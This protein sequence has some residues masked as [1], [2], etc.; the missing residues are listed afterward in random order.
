MNYK[1]KNF[2]SVIYSRE[3]VKKQA[4]YYKTM[5]SKDDEDED[6]NLIEKYL[7]YSERNR[8]SSQVKIYLDEYIEGPKYYRGVFDKVISLNEEDQVIYFVSSKGGRMDGLITLIEANRQCNAEILCVIIGECHSAASMFALTCS[9]I[10]VSPSATMMV[11]YVSF[12]TG[13]KASDIRANVNHTLEFTEEYFREVYEGFLTE[14]EIDICINTGKELW[15]KSDEIIDRLESRQKYLEE[16]D[17][18]EDDEIPA[19]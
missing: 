9:N 1:T 13:G 7:G 2:P 10:S 15:F 18:E 5:V 17:K 12:G 4:K 19:N 8:V 14:D 3:V 6:E 11:H 16:L